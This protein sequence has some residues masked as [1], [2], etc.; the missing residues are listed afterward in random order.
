MVPLR[1]PQLPEINHR[2]ARGYL[3]GENFQLRSAHP[4]RGFVL[5]V[6]VELRQGQVDS[7]AGAE[8]VAF[9]EVD[10]ALAGGVIGVRGGQGGRDQ[11]W[12]EDTILHPI[13]DGERVPA[14]ANRVIARSVAATGAFGTVEYR[15]APSIAA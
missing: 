5:G 15:Y 1:S 14:V 11:Q 7:C 10:F 6:G 3:G 9:D 4:R 8:A 2:T 12:R 13:L